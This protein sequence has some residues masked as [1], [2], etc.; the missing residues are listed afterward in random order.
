MDKID[1]AFT[2][3]RKKRDKITI[4]SSNINLELQNLDVLTLDS[5]F[6]VS[7]QNNENGKSNLIFEFDIKEKH[8][9]SN[10]K[11]VQHVHR[12]LQILQ[13]KTMMILVKMK[14]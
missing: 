1:F 11:L 12:D 2:D 6:T 14:F 4:N 8:N 3:T 5:I 9:K 7:R 10:Q 13:Q